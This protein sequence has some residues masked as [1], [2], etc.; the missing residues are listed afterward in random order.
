MNGEKTKIGLKYQASSLTH[1]AA[2]TTIPFHYQH[3]VFKKAVQQGRRGF[4]ERSVQ[5]YVST[6]NSRERSWPGFFNTLSGIMPHDPLEYRIKL[7]REFYD[8]AILEF[9]IQG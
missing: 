1:Y 4:G 9:R 5:Q 8:I 3:R 7:M 6:T 2:L